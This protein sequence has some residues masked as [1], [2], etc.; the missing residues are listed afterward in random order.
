MSN[1]KKVVVV[2]LHKYDY[3]VSKNYLSSPKELWLRSLKIKK[4]QLI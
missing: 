2:L 4:Y 1:M 3:L